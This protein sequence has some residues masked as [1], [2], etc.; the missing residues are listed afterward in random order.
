MSSDANTNRANA[1]HSTGPR[2]EAGKKNSSQNALRHGLT[3]ETVVLPTEDADAYH[4]H[5]QSFLDQYQPQ[6]PTELH[7]ATT[8]AETSWRLRRVASLEV[9]ALSAAS[10]DSQL[11]G[12][13]ILSTHGQRLSRQF[14]RTAAELR[15]LQT[16]RL[17]QETWEL[18]QLLAVMDMHEAK[19]KEYDP[20]ADGFVF[21]ESRI[22]QA[23]LA[24]NRARLASEA[25]PYM[26]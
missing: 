14:E 26:G 7:L 4:A 8:L 23:I 3:G 13:A 25:R 20:S 18:T 15:D 19:G 9:K 2:T 16:S 11:K 5:L 21:S 24:R 10:L 6:N 1:Q 12:L 17:N 22:E